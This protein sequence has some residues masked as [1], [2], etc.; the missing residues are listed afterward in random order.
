LVE[1]VYHA[2]A[3]AAAEAASADGLFRYGSWQAVVTLEAMVKLL[4]RK[5]MTR[6]VPS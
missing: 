2:S 5:V 6:S 4:M 3:S 1:D